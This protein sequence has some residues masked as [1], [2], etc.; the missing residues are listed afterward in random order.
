MLVSIKTPQNNPLIKKIDKK[1]ASVV[2]GLL[3][4]KKYMLVVCSYGLIAATQIGYRILI[5]LWV[6][7]PAEDGGLGWKS[8]SN[9]GIVQG[10]GAVIIIVSSYWLV[11]FSSKM[12]GNLKACILCIVFLIPLIILCSFVNLI[13]GVSFWFSIIFFQGS[14][15][16]LFTSFISLI[17][18]EISNSVHE[19]V[20]GSANGLSQGLV[21]L[22]SALTSAITGWLYGWTISNQRS[23]PLDYH[24]AYFFLCIILVFNLYVTWMST[25]K[26][27]LVIKKETEL[28]NMLEIYEEDSETFKS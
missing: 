25:E 11:P 5:A 12:L 14:I 18:I 8:T 1:K 3:A 17:S 4:N 27:N 19:S 24:F 21:A 22:Y 20:V 10:A 7:T 2:S 23:F 26:T 28:S 15:M 6:K 16:A 9:L 13:A